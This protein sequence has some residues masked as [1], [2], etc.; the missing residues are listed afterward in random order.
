MNRTISTFLSATAEAATLADVNIAAGIA[1]QELE[2]ER[3]SSRVRS[4]RR[5]VALAAA[6]IVTATIGGDVFAASPIHAGLIKHHPHVFTRLGLRDWSTS[7]PSVF[8]RPLPWGHAR[9]SIEA[10]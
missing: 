7:G 5:V 2:L 6:T 4:I 10:D 3:R 8:G 1:S 9:A